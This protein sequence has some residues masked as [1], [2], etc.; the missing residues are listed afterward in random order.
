MSGSRIL[1]PY[2]W[3]LPMS[4]K[5]ARADVLPDRPS[6]LLMGWTDRALQRILILGA[7]ATRGAQICPGRT[8]NPR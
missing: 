7:L 3:V 8:A 5:G 1:S 4:A 6:R 2:A